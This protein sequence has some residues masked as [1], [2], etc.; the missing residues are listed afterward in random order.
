MGKPE[1][2]VRKAWLGGRADRAAERR[3]R[4]VGAVG[5]RKRRERLILGLI[6]FFK[7][8]QKSIRV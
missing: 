1:E 2:E 8:L 4:R 6:V 3:R 5:L 7:E